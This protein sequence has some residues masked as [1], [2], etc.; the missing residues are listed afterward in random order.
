MA[1]STKHNN[2]PMLFPE[3]EQ[4]RLLEIANQRL[5]EASFE[6]R[7]LSLP[8][9]VFPPREVEKEKLLTFENEL[10]GFSIGL[11]L[12]RCYGEDPRVPSERKA[13][14][15][16]P[17]AQEISTKYRQERDT[18]MLAVFSSDLA[19]E[20]KETLLRIASHPLAMSGA[21]LTVPFIYHVARSHQQE[22]QVFDD[23]CKAINNFATE[24]GLNPGKF[25]K[26]NNLNWKSTEELATAFIENPLS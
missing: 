25:I 13:L 17:Y 8:S 24:Y 9:E 23:I 2:T 19:N 26:G 7:N 10:P 4:D 3:L 5:L 21:F 16:G 18:A 12:E 14:T 15:S 20:P 22:T 11:V 1:R 6:N